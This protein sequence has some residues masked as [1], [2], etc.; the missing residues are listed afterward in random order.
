MFVVVLDKRHS[1]GVQTRIVIA[2]FTSSGCTVS[3][4]E[5]YESVRQGLVGLDIALLINN[6]G[7]FKPLKMM[8]DQPPIFS[9][10]TTG[11]DPCLDLLECN[12][13]A[14]MVMC[15]IVMPLM[16]NGNDII[17]DG[18]KSQKY[19]EHDKETS[20]SSSPSESQSSSTLIR[21]G[22]VINISSASSILPCPL[23][24][25]YATTKVLIHFLENNY[26]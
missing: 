25:L 12:A 22:V 8:L 20:L 19:Q 21:G 15:Q 4:T 1:N 7:I 11:K 13:Q 6:A 9:Y 18:N 2:D 17:S 5:T 10:V 23:F 26:Y 16:I 14:A 3:L 24:T